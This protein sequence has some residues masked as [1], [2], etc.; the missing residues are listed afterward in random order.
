M[1]K[2]KDFINQIKKLNKVQLFFIFIFV[3]L[4]ILIGIL[5]ANVFTTGISNKKSNKTN[6]I[7]PNK[8]FKVV[9]ALPK[10]ESILNSSCKD[11]LAK[12]YNIE[13]QVQLLSN[14]FPGTIDLVENKQADA[15]ISCHTPW[16]LDNQRHQNKWSNIIPIQPF[17]VAKFGIYKHKNDNFDLKSFS[18]NDN[19]KVLIPNDPTNVHFALLYLKEYGLVELN[20]KNDLS[21]SMFY[22]LNDLKS[23]SKLKNENFECKTY[24]QIPHAFKQQSEYKL[25]VNYPNFMN[26]NNYEKIINDNN[27]NDEFLLKKKEFNIFSITLMSREDNKD[28]EKIKYLKESLQQDEIIKFCDEQFPNTQI[29]INNKDDID[30]IMQNIE[31]IM[32]I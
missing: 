6:Y 26:D 24:G 32:K 12:K 30:K 22:S 7:K 16:L 15:V 27:N 2:L 23:D 8:I 1:N 21:T 18:V 11:Y 5:F 4:S 3:L 29:I 28:S 14:N 31:D 25:A 17:Y 9:T 13:L 10:V 19:F 20:D